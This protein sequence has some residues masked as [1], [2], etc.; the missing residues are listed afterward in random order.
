MS[1]VI[2]TCASEAYL[3]EEVDVGA[4]VRRV[5]PR[6]GT[7]IAAA[8]LRYLLLCLGFLAFFVG[9]LYVVARYFAIIPVVVFEGAGVGQAFS[10][11]SQLSRGRKRHILNTLGLVG[12]IYLVVYFGLLMAVALIGNFVIQ[13]VVR[14]VVAVLV[15]PVVAIAEALLYYDA[16]IQSEG[17]DVE[18]MAGALAPAPSATTS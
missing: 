10:R 18:L 14:S 15:Y 3:G 6:A 16:R 5:L 4:A 7:I 1:A 8:L 2:L 17:L 13:A 11:S 9:A 12:L